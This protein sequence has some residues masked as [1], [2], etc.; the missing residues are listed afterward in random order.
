ME[1]GPGLRLPSRPFQALL[2]LRPGDTAFGN[3]RAISQ[4]D[5]YA[6]VVKTKELV[7]S[8]GIGELWIDSELSEEGEG[9]VAEVAALP[10][11]QDDLH[12]AEPS[13]TG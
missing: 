11:D 10:G 8:V 4:H 6:P 5:G 2:E 9:L 1:L 3:H 13:A 12:E 7:V